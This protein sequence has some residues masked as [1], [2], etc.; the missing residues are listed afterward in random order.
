M[1]IKIF[2]VELEA[3]FADVEFIEKYE[4]GLEKMKEADKEIGKLEKVSEQIKAY[5]T[6]LFNFFDELFGE[7]TADKLF[8]GKYNVTLC[9]SAFDILLN[10][11]MTGIAEQ[12]KMNKTRQKKYDKFIVDMNKL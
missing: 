11:I 4:N 8:K 7:G 12:Q 1:I 5:C 10:N 9:D 3:D 2:D 6:T